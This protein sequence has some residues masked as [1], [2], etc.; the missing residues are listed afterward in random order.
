MLTTVKLMPRRLPAACKADAHRFERAQQ[1]GPGI[2]R[3]ICVHCSHV[4]IDLTAQDAPPN[5]RLFTER[6]ETTPTP[7]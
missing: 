2:I 6:T 4:S 1:V 7:K 5:P 3:R